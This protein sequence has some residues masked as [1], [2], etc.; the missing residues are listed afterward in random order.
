MKVSI[1]TATYNNAATI[2]SC[3]KSV[4]KQ[5]WSD[6]EH[7]IVDGAS[8]DDTL[9]MLNASP[10]RVT[11]IVSEPDNGIYEAINKGIQ[12][13]S[14]DIIGILN[15]DD[16]FI[17]QHAVEKIVHTFVDKGTDC[18]YGNLVFTNKKGK[19]VRV[20][21]SK[22]FI[23]GLFEK[24]WTPAHPTFYCKKQMYEKYGLYKT[25]YRIAA[26]V[27]L[28]LR[29]ITI[30]KIKYHYLNEFLVNM[31]HGGVSTRGPRS[32]IVITREMRCAFREHDLP[33]NMLKY[34]FFKFLKVR[35][36]LDRKRTV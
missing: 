33:F 24:S 10:N 26:D 13:A 29:F 34:L 32:T 25:D 8:T 9:N 16:V 35:E 3:L 28:M 21:R 7:I 5:T 4:N 27:E 23:S 30:H 1:I 20:W 17:N 6:I 11:K 18:V 12:L 14:G 19:I 2:D 31:R 22:P 36:Y 15:A